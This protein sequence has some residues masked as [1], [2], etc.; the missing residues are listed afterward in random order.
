MLITC[1]LCGD[2][3]LLSECQ[4]NKHLYS[5]C[6][7]RVSFWSKVWY[8]K[9]LP[10][11]IA[12]LYTK[13]L[14][15]EYSGT[16][17][18]TPIIKWVRVSDSNQ[19]RPANEES[20]RLVYNAMASIIVPLFRLDSGGAPTLASSTYDL[21]RRTGSRVS[22][23]MLRDVN[24][25]VV[26]GI[27]YLF[28]TTRL[29]CEE[30]HLTHQLIRSKQR[31]YNKE[32]ISR[33]M[34]TPRAFRVFDNI[35][36]KAVTKYSSGDIEDIL[37]TP[38]P[39]E[40]MIRSWITT[41]SQSSSHKRKRN[42]VLHS[43]TLDFY[44]QYTQVFTEYHKD[45]DASIEYLVQQSYDVYDDKLVAII[46]GAVTSSMDPMV[47]PMVNPSVN[48][49][50]MTMVPFVEK[51]SVSASS[52]MV[53]PEPPIVYSDMIRLKLSLITIKQPT[54]SDPPT[55]FPQWLKDQLHNQAKANKQAI[56]SRE[57]EEAEFL[58][59]DQLRIDKWL[60]EKEQTTATPL[61]SSSSAP[62]RP[63][64]KR[65]LKNWNCER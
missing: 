24:E 36:Q 33:A 41:R 60:L 39:E 12:V 7:N 44:Y 61:S 13:T 1:S 58:R 45:P 51:S 62:V 53:A 28:H 23:A 14:P 37:S 34:S 26:D 20:S 25:C 2:A 21:P 56:E 46:T 27:P 16:V 3:S 52:L 55:G 4:L 22:R 19:F 64:W 17:P 6:V 30:V 9:D 63:D 15:M 47:N 10:F 54:K 29:I 40:S 42:E 31:K 18:D 5:T 57:R 8:I 48:P 50:V 38:I 11:R 59:Q 49:S 35:V 32:V 43:L 65:S